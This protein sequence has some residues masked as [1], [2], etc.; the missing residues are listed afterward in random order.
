ME[1]ISGGDNYSTTLYFFNN[2]SMSYIPD[3]FNP[4]TDTLVMGD[5]GLIWTHYY[6]VNEILEKLI[7]VFG[8]IF[9]LVVYL[10]YTYI[11]PKTILYL[12]AKYGRNSNDDET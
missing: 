1:N 2:S 9:I 8:L 11:A 7:P 3:G 6:T 4:E 12:K 10:S 5:N